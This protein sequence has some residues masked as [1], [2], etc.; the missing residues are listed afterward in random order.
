VQK[1]RNHTFFRNKCF[2]W[3][4]RR[5]RQVSKTTR[6][7][8]MCGFLRDWRMQIGGLGGPGGF[9]T[10]LQTF[11]GGPNR[12]KTVHFFWKMVV[13]TFPPPYVRVWFVGP[14]KSFDQKTLRDP[15]DFQS[16][17][18]CVSPDLAEFPFESCVRR[19]KLF[20]PSLSAT[21]LNF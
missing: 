8:S 6:V 9:G 3:P 13:R 4:C 2:C 7:L 15:F 1:Q 18:F 20:L 12:P 5:R 21:F 19:P 10:P 17:F 16:L 11:F 14:Q